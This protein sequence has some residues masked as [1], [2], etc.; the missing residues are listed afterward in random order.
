MNGKRSTIIFLSILLLLAV[1][2]TYV[3]T[4]SFLRPIAYAVIFAVVFYPLHNQMMH[5]TRQRSGLA[6]LLSTLILLFVF[7]VPLVILTLKAAEEALIVAGYLSRRSAEQGG[8]ARFATALIAEPLQF[9]GRWVDLS[10]YDIP[11]IVRA[12]VEKFGLWMVGFGANILGNFARFVGNA[13]ITLF[14]LFFFFRDGRNWALHAGGLMPL[15]SAQVSKLYRNIADT[16][17]ANVYGIVSVAII[18]GTL[19]GVALRMVGI[20][21]AL[22]LGVTAGFCSILPVVGAAIVWAPAGLYLLFSGSVGKGIFVLFWGAVVISLV[23]NFVRPW[24][25]SGKAELHPLVL[26]FFILGGVEAFGF[27]GIFLGPVVASVL[28]AIFG[29]LREE[30]GETADETVPAAKG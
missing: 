22:L 25:V 12:N 26:L 15:S 5:W 28:V 3:I 21:S 20:P 30:L 13:F 6:A 23:D 29:M 14:V 10:K 19:T 18:Q 2:L 17:V 24:V 4:K 11:A 9:I 7:M 27:L 8:F 16:I 1:A